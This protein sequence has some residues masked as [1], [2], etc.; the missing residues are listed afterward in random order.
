MD[1]MKI[2]SAFT[3]NIVSKLIRG[4]IKK[5][6]GYDIDIRLS[7]FSTTIIDGK[8]H[9]HLDVDAELEKSEL[10]KILKTIGLN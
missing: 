3:R 7:D 4:V 5:K 6:T 10:I 8:T 2:T 1:E 9:V